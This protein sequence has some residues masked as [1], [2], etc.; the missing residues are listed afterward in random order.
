MY[1]VGFFGCLLA[2]DGLRLL[3]RFVGVWEGGG[4][5]LFYM[6]IRLISYVGAGLFVLAWI[7]K[8]PQI[9][10]WIGASCLLGSAALMMVAPPLF[11]RTQII[12]SLVV[13]SLC[14]FFAKT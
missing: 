1:V 5:A 11:V 6:G 9:V 3:G 8:L 13:A 12:G 7:K 14:L 10:K 4:N 2:A